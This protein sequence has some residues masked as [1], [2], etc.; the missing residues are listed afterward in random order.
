MTNDQYIPAEL[1]RKLVNIGT[2]IYGVTRIDV[3]FICGDAYDN[4]FVPINQ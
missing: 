2:S 3:I 4:A 1:N